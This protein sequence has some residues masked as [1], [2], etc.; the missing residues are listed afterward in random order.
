MGKEGSKV[1]FDLLDI[2]AFPDEEG[3]YVRVSQHLV[4]GV[5]ND[6]LDAIIAAQLLENC[7]R[8]PALDLRGHRHIA[9]GL[10]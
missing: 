2:E 5:L 7:P 9:I 1:K 4:E 3:S 6:S 8:Q 10:P